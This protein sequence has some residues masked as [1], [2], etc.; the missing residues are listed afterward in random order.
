MKLAAPLNSNDSTPLASNEIRAGSNA[1]FLKWKF[2]T[3]GLYLCYTTLLV[4]FFLPPALRNDIFPWLV[5]LVAPL[6]ALLIAW[7]PRQHGPPD[8]PPLA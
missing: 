5:F 6:P 2:A 7:F 4:R 1:T 8:N 3:L